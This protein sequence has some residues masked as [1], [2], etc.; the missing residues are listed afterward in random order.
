M[1]S[2]K[3][4]PCGPCNVLER[5]YGLAEIVEREKGCTAFKWKSDSNDETKYRFYKES[6][7]CHPNCP[8]KLW[9]DECDA[10]GCPGIYM[11]YQD[12]A[13]DGHVGSS[14]MKKCSMHFYCIKSNT[15]ELFDDC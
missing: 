15:D 10:K 14:P 2:A 6:G 7:G 4:A 13:D 12:C 11:V 9:K 8:Y 1:R 3:H 5:R